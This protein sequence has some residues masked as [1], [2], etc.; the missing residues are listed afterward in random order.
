MRQPSLLGHLQFDSDKASLKTGLGMKETA[1]RCGG[2]E[3]SEI[4]GRTFALVN[5]VVIAIISGLHSFKR[6]DF[7]CRGLDLS[8]RADKRSCSR[9]C[10]CGAT[11]AETQS[12]TFS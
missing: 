11:Q 6:M 2:G 3:R 12:W 8:M 7:R 5:D 10:C 9:C 1:E 4:D